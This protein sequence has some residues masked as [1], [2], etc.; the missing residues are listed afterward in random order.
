MA[1][2][3]KVAIVGCGRTGQPLLKELKKHKYIKVVGVADINEKSPGMQFAK[4]SRIPATKNFMDLAKKGRNVDMIIDVS[5]NKTV[6]DTLKK[7]YKKT[8]NT[9]TI[10]VH[11]LIV[12]LIMSMSQRLG[13]LAKTY[14][15]NIKGI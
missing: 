11:E 14:H 9:H 8:K 7:Y 1:D 13:K 3:V 2:I 10:I 5:G 12:R 6:R 15:P 4:K